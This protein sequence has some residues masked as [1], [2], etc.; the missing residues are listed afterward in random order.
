MK[1]SSVT[2]AQILE[3]IIAIVMG[4][5]T[6]GAFTIQV[7]TLNKNTTE[8]ETILFNG[9]QF[10]LSLG[11]AWFS[12]RAISRSEFDESIKK[13]AI[14]AYRRISDI[15]RMISRLQNEIGN[16][17][18]HTSDHELH[19]L[20]IV[21]AIVADTIQVVKSSIADWSDVIGDELIVIEKIKRLE[22]DKVEKESSLQND[23]EDYEEKLKEINEQITK[24]ISSLPNNLKYDALEKRETSRHLEF[25]AIWLAR[26]HTEEGGLKLS[27]VT[28]DIYS[29]ERDYMLLKEHEILHTVKTDGYGIDVADESDALLGRLQNNSPLNYADFSKAFELCYGSHPVKLEFIEAIKGEK[30]N[31]VF[32]GWFHI[33]VLSNPVAEIKPS[34]KRLSSH[35][36]PSPKK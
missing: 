26:R 18:A 33:K 9:I 24:L 1:K 4:S 15:E 8:L 27:V 6:V 16:M 21:N 32:Y 34:R 25:A 17:M 23:K 13:F 10:I 12:T 19:H 22:E 35:R 28:G 20:E 36:P 30:R 14:G 7:V 5:L 2:H 3:I 11:F 31:E 29:H